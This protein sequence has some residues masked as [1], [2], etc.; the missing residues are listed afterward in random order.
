MIIIGFISIIM[1]LKSGAVMEVSRSLVRMVRLVLKYL[2]RI[3]LISMRLRYGRRMV[4]A[5]PD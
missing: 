1:I 3:L 4:N 5:R 2:R